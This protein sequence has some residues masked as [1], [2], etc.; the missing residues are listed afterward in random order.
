MDRVE[1]GYKFIELAAT[2]N[3]R[4]AWLVL[5]KCYFERRS[6]DGS[7]ILWSKLCYMAAERLKADA[8]TELSIGAL[9][10]LEGNM[11]EFTKW[12]KLAAEKGF[13]MQT[14]TVIAGGNDAR[15]VSNSTGGVK[16]LTVSFATRYLHSASC[17][18]SKDDISEMSLAVKYISEEFANA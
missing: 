12:M 6:E 16:T 11:Q 14:K 5:G 13:K 4:E 10:G 8:D 15:A 2:Q 3:Y 7:Y 1:E 17:V 18:I 9:A